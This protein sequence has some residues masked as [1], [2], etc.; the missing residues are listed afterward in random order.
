MPEGSPGRMALAVRSRAIR[1]MPIRYRGGI[2]LA[3]GG[4]ERAK[5]DP[6]PVVNGE[7]TGVVD[8]TLP[9]HGLPLPLAT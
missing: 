9:A 4:R 6:K 7:A 8:G 1:P 2:P 5:E 3:G